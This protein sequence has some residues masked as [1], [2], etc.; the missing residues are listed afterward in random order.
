MKK[1][2]CLLLILGLAI[3]GC[4]QQ[5]PQK[6]DK[7]KPA[8][9][10]RKIAD[11]ED[12]DD[13]EAAGQ[14]YQ[15]LTK[16]SF[17]HDIR[18]QAFCRWLK[19]LQRQG[20]NS[21]AAMV[22]EKML[23][24]FPDRGGEIRHQLYRHYIATWQW[25]KL[26]KTIQEMSN[27]DFSD[28]REG[29][30]WL[31]RIG[32]WRQRRMLWEER[33]LSLTDWLLAHPFYYKLE[34]IKRHLD[35]TTVTGSWYHAG[36]LFQWQGDSTC[37]NCEI[38]IATIDWMGEVRFGIFSLTSTD[39]LV[40]RFS[41]GGGT[42]DL[43][44]NL[45]LQGKIAKQPARLLFSA[46]DGYSTKTWYRLTI[47]YLAEIGQAR[48]S[49]RTREDNRELGE[50]IIQLAKKFGPEQYAIGLALV[51]KNGNIPTAFAQV[52]IDNITLHGRLW[53][54]SRQRPP[55]T[56]IYNINS[57]IGTR[58]IQAGKYCDKLVQKSPDSYQALETRALVFLETRQQQ[59][60][61]D[62]LQLLLQR[63]PKHRNCDYFV[64]LI[65]RLKQD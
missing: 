10:L 48:L 65:K 63:Y 38:Q 25:Q 27:N 26:E 19:L 51:P 2:G 42:G 4:R 47:D 52:Q 32:H 8:T 9:M 46:L 12:W 35:A 7:A 57:L 45:D 43:H 11:L 16:D 49:L 6:P 23:P 41:C 58:P 1:L 13:W 29:Q 5:R 20:M 62:D 50:C 44:Y 17:P 18:Y 59:K 33:F 55:L 15:Q 39:C 56:P 37:I 60:C 64:K 61:R 30:A 14:W 24:I 31:S 40:A 54:K 21:E 36:K 53:K 3:G 34:P 22:Q 28:D